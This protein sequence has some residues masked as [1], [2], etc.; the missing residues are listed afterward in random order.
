MISRNMTIGVLFGGPSGEY[1]VSCNSAHTIISALKENGYAPFCIGVSKDGHWYGPVK[2]KDVANFEP[3]NYSEHEIILPQYPGG[4][5]YDARNGHAVVTLDVVF[6]IIHG[7]Y[8]EDGHVQALLDMVRIPYV[9]A[10]M[11]GSVVGMDKVLMRD[12]LRAHG[13]AQ[14]DYVAVRRYDLDADQESVL[15]LLEKQLPYPMFVKPSCMG[16][17]V[18]ISKVNERAALL[19]GLKEAARYDSKLMVEKGVNAREIETAILGNYAAEMAVPGEILTAGQFYDY[20][21]KYILDN[22]ETR[23]P[24]E[25]DEQTA[26]DLRRIAVKTYQALDLSGFCRVDFFIDR[27][28]GRILLN[29]VNT[30]PGF[31]SISM[32]PKMWEA[33]GKSL[34]DI[35]ECLIEL[36]F[37]RHKDTMRNYVVLGGN[38]DGK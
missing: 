36:A 37:E 6:P 8:G 14:T 18:G 19:A 17:S 30:L 2:P 15:D 33:S 26:A 12:I 4:T 5:L 31:T 38:A 24:A 27:D 22:S 34:I 35:I 7:P 21:S 16:S 20:D 32:Y 1:R 13:I 3:D 29:E 25:I 23:V 11:A 10:G 28:N 9:G